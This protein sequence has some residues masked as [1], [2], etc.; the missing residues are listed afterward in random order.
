MQQKR[1]WPSSCGVWRIQRL[2][3]GK[4]HCRYLELNLTSSSHDLDWSHFL[5][6][7]GLNICMFPGWLVCSSCTGPAGSP[8]TWRDPHE[9]GDSSDFVRAL[10]RPICVCEKEGPAVCGGPAQCEWSHMLMGRS[11]KWP[12]V[13][14]NLTS[15]CQVK[16]ECS[17]VQKAWLQGVVPAVAD[18]ETSVQDKAL[19]ALDQV[20]LSQ[21]K[22][23]SAG[24][25]LDASQRLMWELLGLLCHQCQKLRWSQ[26]SVCLV[27]NNMF[28]VKYWMCL[29]PVSSRYFSKAFT[30]WSKQKKFTPLFVSNLISH[31]EA[32]H[33][34]GAWL[35]LSKVVSSS[36]RLPHGKILDAWDKMVRWASPNQS[37]TFMWIKMSPL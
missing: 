21:V 32:D 13:R 9:L 27:R 7:G 24:C 36:S 18:S 10:Q 34:A 35:L 5:W 14:S 25:H 30:I 17:V 2:M 15:L 33:A 1:I 11:L 37:A 28:N 16:P 22:P 8:E 20:L 6:G 23:Y 26:P 3:W 4:Q 12:W 29:Y 31:T 19:E